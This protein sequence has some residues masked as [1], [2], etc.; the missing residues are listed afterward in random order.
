MTGLSAQ[1]VINILGGKTQR[2]KRTTADRVMS[3]TLNDK[4]G[5]RNLVPSAKAR[6]M[7][8]QMR[9]SGILAKTIVAMLGYKPTSSIPTARHQRIAFRNH[10][11]ICV[12]YELLARQ[13]KVPASLLEEANA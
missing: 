1:A 10:R 7:L 12:L 4:P 13:G 5:A 2:V 9:R 8:V 3:V 6:D 11:R